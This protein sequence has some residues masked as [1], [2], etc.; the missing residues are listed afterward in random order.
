MSG[1][2]CD[3][4]PLWNYCRDSNSDGVDL[5]KLIDENIDKINT[6]AGRID[7]IKVPP[8]TALLISSKSAERKYADAEVLLRRGANV[9]CLDE[10]GQSAVGYMFTNYRWPTENI[11]NIIFLL[12]SHSGLLVKGRT[13]SFYLDLDC[14]D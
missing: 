7:D 2:I 1:H 11:Q 13:T 14:E 4:N 6:L 10:W 5:H 12:K 3:M 8:L 9:N